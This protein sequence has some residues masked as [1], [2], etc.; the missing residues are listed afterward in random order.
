[1]KR[2]ELL[3]FLLKVLLFGVPL[4]VL[5]VQWLEG[6]YPYALHA[7][8]HPI[9][10]L[11]GV[12]KWWMALLL[13]HFANLIPF[14]TLVLATPDLWR[15]L[16]HSALGLILGL[17]SLVVMHMVLVFAVYYCNLKFG[18]RQ[19]FHFITFP[20]YLINDILPFAFWYLWFPQ[21]RELFAR[22][23]VPQSIP[24]AGPE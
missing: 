20:L 2:K 18:L 10:D 6:R 4:C 7:A 1:V 19:E 22:R 8:V 5:W 13:F 23:T 3:K 11:L 21:V 9:L 24:V 17:A 16:R 15:R 12:K 14:V